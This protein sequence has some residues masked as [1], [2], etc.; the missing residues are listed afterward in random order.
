MLSAVSRAFV[1]SSLLSHAVAAPAADAVPTLPGFGAPL[2]SAYSGYLDI[3]GGK[4]L[5]YFAYTSLGNPSVDPIV[6]WFNGAAPSP[7]PPRVV[8]AN[9]YRTCEA[10]NTV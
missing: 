5:H 6:F 3:P 8:A 7:P 2:S 1:V 9:T 10:L 4:H